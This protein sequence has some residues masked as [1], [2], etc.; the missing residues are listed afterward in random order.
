MFMGL[1]VCVYCVINSYRVGSQVYCIYACVTLINLKPERGI[2]KPF[3]HFV[4]P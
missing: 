1:S 4:Q 2:Y 3:Y